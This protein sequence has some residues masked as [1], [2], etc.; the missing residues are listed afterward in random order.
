MGVV[1]KIPY[2]HISR[3]SERQM[4]AISIAQTDLEEKARQVLMMSEIFEKSRHLTIWL[5][6]PNDRKEETMCARIHER[7]LAYEFNTGEYFL[8]EDEL[9]T[10][11]QILLRRWFRRRWI[12]QEALVSAVSVMPLFRLGTHTWNWE[13]F[14]VIV[15]RAKPTDVVEWFLKLVQPASSDYNLM[16]YGRP[17][18]PSLLG[19][20][21]RILTQTLFQCLH[22]FDRAE[23]YD[24]RDKIYSLLSITYGVGHSIQVD[25][26]SSVEAV[27]TGLAQDYIIADEAYIED[28]LAMSSCRR[29]QSPLASWIPDWRIPI[30]YR[31]D[32]HQEALETYM[33]KWRPS[34][35]VRQGRTTMDRN[36]I[37]V[38]DLSVIKPCFHKDDEEPKARCS[39]CGLLKEADVLPGNLASCEHSVRLGEDETCKDCM[40]DIRLMQD[41]TAELRAL[42]IEEVLCFST[43]W[44]IAFILSETHAGSTEGYRV[45]SCLTFRRRQTSIFETWR[46]RL[47][48]CAER[49]NVRIE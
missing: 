43:G 25:Y 13:F 27:Y 15:E 5:G 18:Q 39:L 6:E 22:T 37:I 26:T 4:D 41:A 30:H 44:S 38:Q 28:L 3:L 1:G 19:P 12:I 21:K 47:A 14:S 42:R 33:K 34:G 24:P 31:S 40:D 45:V 8:D 11:Q 16:P 17:S 36:S 35:L 32:K 2:Q 20:T 10:L 23:C 29:A 49:K 46:R 48:E 9:E 7:F